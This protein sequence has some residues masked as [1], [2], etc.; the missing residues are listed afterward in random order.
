MAFPA[1]ITT[2]ASKPLDRNPVAGL[3]GEALGL[4]REGHVRVHILEISGIVQLDVRAVVHEG[5]DGHALRQHRNAPHVVAIVVRHHHIIDLPD[6][7]G[8]TGFHDAVRLTAAA[9]VD[10]HTLSGG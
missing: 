4:G 8:L 7:Q 1:A 3:H 5:H 10:N 6:A 2:N 9:G